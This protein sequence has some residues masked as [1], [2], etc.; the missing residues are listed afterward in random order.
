MWD[1]E[2]WDLSLETSPVSRNVRHRLQVPDD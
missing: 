1:G 2:T